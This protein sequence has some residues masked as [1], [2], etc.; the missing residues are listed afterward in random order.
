MSGKT[1]NEPGASC[2][3]ENKEV[4]K[5]QKDRA[6]QRHTGIQTKRAPEG[7]SWN[8]LSNYMNNK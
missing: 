6:C 1:Y 4:L 8:N 5:A 7:Q 2:G 3:T